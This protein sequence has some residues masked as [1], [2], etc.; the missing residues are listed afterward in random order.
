MSPESNYASRVQKQRCSVCLNSNQ[1]KFCYPEL[2]LHQRTL[3]KMW[4]TLRG[5]WYGNFVC[6][7][8]CRKAVLFQMSCKNA[9]V[10]ISSWVTN[11]GEDKWDNV[12]KST[13]PPLPSPDICPTITGVPDSALQ[14]EA[15]F[16]LLDSAQTVLTSHLLYGSWEQRTTLFFLGQE[17][18][19]I[20]DLSWFGKSASPELSPLCLTCLASYEQDSMS[21]TILALLP[22]PVCMGHVKALRTSIP[23][24]AFLPPTSQ[25]PQDVS[26]QRLIPILHFQWIVLSSSLLEL[27]AIRKNLGN[28]TGL[29]T[30]KGL[31][32]RET[33]HW[34]H[35]LVLKWKLWDNKR[36][37][38]STCT[39]G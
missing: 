18:Q 22:V 20:L 15:L 3:F 6:E 13:L 34:S 33:P 5:N 19:P 24:W 10:I 39:P 38:L 29:R 30:A 14:P 32:T 7:A 27:W 23:S 8:C 31:L 17:P 36:W 4:Q 35:L 1:K 37:K 26:S 2:W 28:I 16:S 9:T 12:K 21:F 25:L 11:L